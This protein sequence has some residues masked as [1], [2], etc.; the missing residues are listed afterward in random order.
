[1]ARN[2]THCLYARHGQ[3]WRTLF[4]AA[5]VKTDPVGEADLILAMQDCVIAA[6]NAVV[7]AQSL[8]L[9]SC[10]ICGILSSHDKH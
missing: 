9:G 8:G 3:R 2:P 1:M 7:A 6:Q 4:E 10:Y 5:G